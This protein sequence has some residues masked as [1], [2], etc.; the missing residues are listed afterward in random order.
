MTKVSEK[1]LADAKAEAQRIEADAAQQV[2]Q[3]LKQADEEA[4]KLEAQLEQDV[5]QATETHRLQLLARTRMGT[6]MDGLRVRQEMMQAVFDEAAKAVCDM[7]DQEY[8]QLVQGWMLK[9]VETGDERVVI[10]KDETRIDQSLIDAANR[11]LNERGRLAL[12]DERRP[13]SGG[14]ILS[15]ERTEVNASLEVML[16]QARTELETELGQVLFGG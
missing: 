11:T 6:R 13:I 16:Q 12:A 1:I 10:G 8:R 3:L 4:K 7:P 14:V 5:Q 2:E 9:A 15:R